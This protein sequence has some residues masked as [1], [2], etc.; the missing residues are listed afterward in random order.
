ML[1]VHWLLRHWNVVWFL[2]R[3]SSIVAF[4]YQKRRVSI[5]WNNN[6]IPV[7]VL[8]LV[9][10]QTRKLYQTTHFI[11]HLGIV[12]VPNFPPVNT[13]IFV[14]RDENAETLQKHAVNSV[15]DFSPP[16]N[17]P[18]SCVKV[19]LQRSSRK[20]RPLAPIVGRWWGGPHAGR[21]F[22]QAEKRRCFGSSSHLRVNS[23]DTR[24]PTNWRTSGLQVRSRALAISLCVFLDKTTFL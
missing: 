6:E 4:R 1:C 16:A 10:S 9:T 22:N 18:I 20:W 23:W 21:H 3:F 24:W 11:R 5:L 15:L 14:T 17:L 2:W 19:I 8:R 12:F 13:R 7:S